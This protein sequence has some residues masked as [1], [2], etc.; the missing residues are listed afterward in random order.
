MPANKYALLRYRIIDRLISSKSKPHPTKE[1][2]KEACEESL[3][4]SF[5]E[6][7]SDSTIE[8]DLY[9]MRNEGELGY[10]APIKYS[11]RYN[12]YFY[13]EEN[14][15]IS[16]IPLQEEDLGAIKFAAQTLYQ[17]KDIEIFQQFSSAIAR[18][19]DKIKT[20]PEGV[21]IKE[22]KFIQ[23]EQSISDSGSEYLG[24]LIDAIK[25][26]KKIEVTY[27]SFKKNKTKTYILDPYLLKEYKGRWYVISWSDDRSD[28]LTFSLD[29]IQ[30]TKLL[31]EKFEEVRGFDPDRFFKHSIGITELDGT[32]MKIRL[33]FSALQGKYIK[34]RPIHHSQVL[35]DEN[36][37]YVLVELFALQT[38]E[39][40]Q[41]ILSYG[42]NA[43]V[44]EPKKLR[45]RVK[46]IILNS[47]LKY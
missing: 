16:E 6:R 41:L 31:K 11:K 32:P 13:E 1:E 27:L 34:S 33:K 25:S 26:K 10:Y 47:A 12:G 24:P 2:L 23:F 40:V 19:F 43:E 36:E 44:L 17:F 22:E 39:L 7:I 18:I 14:Y 30:K 35:V 8:K 21:E 20:S 15:S 46:K 45:L 5:G 9:A 4:G 42:D 38:I 28:Y 29:R 3:Y 37:E